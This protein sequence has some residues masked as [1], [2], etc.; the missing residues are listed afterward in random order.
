MKSSFKLLARAAAALFAVLT[1]PAVAQTPLEVT[2]SLTVSTSDGKT[3]VPVLT[4]STTPAA[5][6]T[7][8]GAPDW[9]G[10]KPGSGSATLAAVSQ[11]TDFTLSCSIAGAQNFV[12]TWTKPTRNVDGSVLNDL[13]GYRL[14]WGSNPAALTAVYLDSPDTL[15]WTSPNVAPGT[16]HAQVRALNALGLESTPTVPL[17]SVTLAA[18]ETVTRTLR[19][20]VVYPETPGDLTLT[21]GT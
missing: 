10:A 7:A 16:Y 18:G 3:I 15:T 1:V 12:A 19:V 11:T 21:P 13:A 20:A 14:D 5:N 8:S 6:C 9:S 2:Y 17:R 4:W